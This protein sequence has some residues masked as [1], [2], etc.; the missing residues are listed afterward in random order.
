MIIFHF[1]VINVFETF[2]I[3]HMTIEPYTLLVIF[4]FDK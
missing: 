4:L 2:L 3:D 1:H